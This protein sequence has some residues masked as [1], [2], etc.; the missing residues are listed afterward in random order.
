MYSVPTEVKAIITDPDCLGREAGMT[1]P[2]S[3]F[4]KAAVNFRKIYL[5][6]SYNSIL[7]TRK[8]LLTLSECPTG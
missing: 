4:Q 1:T 5:L 8:E 7:V 6:Y 3:L 2:P